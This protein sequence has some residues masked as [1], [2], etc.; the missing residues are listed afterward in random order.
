MSGVGSH[1][2]CSR[3]LSVLLFKPLRSQMYRAS[4][5]QA[6]GALPATIRPSTK[7]TSG[8]LSTKAA[9]RPK[10]ERLLRLR[11]VLF[12]SHRATPPAGSQAGT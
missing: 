10:R 1:L 9:P 8:L 7:V 3:E 12:R 5:W 4:K 6:F 2:L 11:D